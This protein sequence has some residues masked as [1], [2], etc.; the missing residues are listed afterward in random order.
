[1]PGI[2]YNELFTVAQFQGRFSDVAMQKTEHE[3][4]M[5][6]A[7]EQASDALKRGEFPVGCILVY[8]G[9]V[10]GSGARRSSSGLEMNELDHAEIVAL[11][12]WV[13]TG[14]RGAGG[15]IT[16]YV[17]L[18]PCFMCLGA[19]M[20]NDIRR[21][22]FAYEDVMGGACATDFSRPLTAV[23]GS[24]HSVD[25]CR[26]IYTGYGDLGADTQIIGGVMRR[27][28]LMLFY[29]FFNNESLDYLRGTYLAEYTL[30]QGRGPSL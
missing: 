28:S 5:S 16:A 14:R 12:Y 18:E 2:F 19:L 13:S 23:S 9:A 27:E 11:R 15:V 20:I 1:M 30:Q 21:I 8:E 24:R 7:L 6:L 29:E 3:K 10:V 22:V 17:T 4:W 25:S 26:H